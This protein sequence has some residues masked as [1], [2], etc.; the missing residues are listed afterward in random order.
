MLII[1]KEK[2]K[3]LLLRRKREIERPKY[4][5]I[6]EMISGVSIIFTLCLSDVTKITIMS[7]M[8]FQIISW[9]IAI[10]VLVFG[11]FLFG[12]SVIKRYTIDN[13]F[14]E[15]LDL[16]SDIEH[17]F[18]I[19][20]LKDSDKTG[21]Y[22]LFRSRRWRCWLFPNYHCLDGP[23]DQEAE[24]IHV[25]E[26][27]KRDLGLSGIGE[28]IEV[29]YIGNK[30]SNKYSVGDKVE[31]KYNFHFFWVKNFKMEDNG[32]RIFRFNGKKY[33]WK[34]LDKMY[35]NKNIVKKNKDVL[36]YVRKFGDIS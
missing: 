30:I 16:D 13:L 36:D 6:A 8:L 34:T 29:I 12:K 15:I 32:K 18:D 1:E 21:R 24:I 26:C 25:R 14:D 35:A 22:L 7:P 19:V 23:Y 28:D 27:I 33:Q 11:V 17:P 5:G 9:T 10:I 31:K 2:L 3:I 4:S 20:I